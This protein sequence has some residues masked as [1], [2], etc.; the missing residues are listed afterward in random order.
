MSLRARVLAGVALI[1]VVLAVVTVLITET[2]RANLL[3]QVDAEL[4]SAVG[5]VRGFDLG[6]GRHRIP[7]PAR[8]EPSRLSSLY[9][10]LVDGQRVQ[11]LVAP[12]LAG[13]ATALPSIDTGQAIAS[14][15]TGDPFTVGSDGS[16][17]RYRALTY[18]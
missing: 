8:G 2:T 10:G 5:P 7:G 17:L 16:E 4:A 3:R 15:T 13:G 6:F 18:P 1:A 9:I 12:N 14:A 11:T